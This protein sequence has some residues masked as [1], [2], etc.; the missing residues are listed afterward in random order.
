MSKLIIHSA[1]TQGSAGLIVDHSDLQFSNWIKFAAPAFSISAN[2]EDYFFTTTVLI[3]SDLVNRNSVSVTPSGLPIREVKGRLP[4]DP[5]SWAL[6]RVI[7][8][9]LAAYNTALGCQAYKGWAGMPLHV[10][11]KSE[12][13]HQAIGVVAD[14][15][16]RPI[17]GFNGG[18]IY[19]VMAL[20]AV[21]TTK[22]V[23]VTSKIVTGE[24]N[25]WSMGMMVDG[26]SC[27]YCHAEEGKCQHIDPDK[28]FVFYEK[29]GIAV[30]RKVHGVTPFEFSNV[31]V[32]AF[33]AALSDP[34]WGFTSKIKK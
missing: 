20:C 17:E 6:T 32:G 31:E 3:T 29:N 18:R 13:L 16:M 11:H 22:R 14:V 1:A 15:S 25:S 23:D 8:G 4:T 28:P 9:G 27:T 19:K 2:V 10:E 21:D 5:P 34:T 26:Y 7:G 12:D 33:P 30:A 24:R